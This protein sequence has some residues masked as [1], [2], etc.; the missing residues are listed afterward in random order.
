MFSLYSDGLTRKTCGYGMVNALIIFIENIF[1]DML[2]LTL[3]TQRIWHILCIYALK[4][5]PNNWILSQFFRRSWWKCD[6]FALKKN[7]IFLHFKNS[8]QPAAFQIYTD[9]VCLLWLCKQLFSLGNLFIFLRHSFIFS[10]F[11]SFS[12]SFWINFL[13]ISQVLTYSWTVRIKIKQFLPLIKLK[14]KHKCCH[15]SNTFVHLKINLFFDIWI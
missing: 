1:D 12:L 10:A 11:L 14:Y 5:T 15:L 7:G 3:N 8:V 2:E 9:S 4:W 13:F 6:Y